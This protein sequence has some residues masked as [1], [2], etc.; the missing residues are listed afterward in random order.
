MPNITFM[1]GNG[2]DLQIG[3]KTRYTDFYKIYCEIKDDDDQIIVNFKKNILQDEAHG[4]KNWSDFELGM[5]KYS[6]RFFSEH[7]FIRCFTDFVVQFNE[8]LKNECNSIDWVNVAQTV[9]NEFAE[10]LLNFAQR[11][12]SV[13]LEIINQA[14]GT[15]NSTKSNYAFLQFNYTN[16]FDILLKRIKPQIFP[17][18]YSRAVSH[19]LHIH[20][21]LNNHPA[22]GVD[23]ISQIINYNNFSVDA[24]KTVFVKPLYLETIQARNI[25][26]KI[27]AKKA[28]A[29]IGDSDI[30]CVFG[31]SLGDTDKTWWKEVGDWLKDKGKL[32]IIFDV[33]G[34]KDD[35]I[36]PE[37]FLS[38][39]NAINERK[40]AIF[41]RI[42]T[43]GEW[44][45]IDREQMSEKVVIELDSTLFNFK[46]PKIR[47]DD[48]ST[49]N[50]LI[51]SL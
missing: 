50:I 11:I 17:K 1:I 45:Y 30:I 44:D 41:D 31:A 47:Q 14:L 49:K 42:T 29:A 26:V 18:N 27:P 35:G 33:C 6:D 40:K 43:L 12:K 36:S 28:I 4:W 20:G 21:E 24:I 16:A 5:G 9:N 38:H 39:E 51:P 8:Y 46:L 37:R 34:I 32:L 2:F 3:L 7:S 10:S 13:P 15:P 22:I 23:S 48:E 19:N 25:N